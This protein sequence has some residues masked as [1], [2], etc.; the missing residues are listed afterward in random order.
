M[1]IKAKSEKL[2]DLRAYLE[3]ERKRLTKEIARPDQTAGEERAGYDSH[4]AEGASTV[5]EQARNVGMHR[6][7]ELMLNEVE[8]ALQR[9]ATGSYGACRRCGQPID[10]ARLRVMPMA[11][12]CLACQEHAEAR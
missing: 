7:H 6:T 11:E 2:T 8:E 4:M 12:L 1:D 5:F 10:T 3:K 9:I